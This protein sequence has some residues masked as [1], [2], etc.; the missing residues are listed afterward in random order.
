MRLKNLIK[1]IPYQQGPNNGRTDHFRVSCGAM[2]EVHRIIELS[3]SDHNMIF[4]VPKQPRIE[5]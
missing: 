5:N 2:F 3:A 1:G 4:V